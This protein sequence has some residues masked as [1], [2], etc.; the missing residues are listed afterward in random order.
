MKERL[1]V[2]LDPP[3]MRS[4][5]DYAD[6]RGKSKSLVAEAAIASFLSPD[7]AERLED[8]VEDPVRA[9]VHVQR[10]DDFIPGLQIR[11][12]HR[13]FG[14]EPGA[15]DGGVLH[16]FELRQSIKASWLWI[17]P[18][19]PT[20]ALGAAPEECYALIRANAARQPALVGR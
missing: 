13:I 16:A 6:R 11:L 4:L 17:R 19:S 8:L 5:I 10:D 1:S 7:A 15:E 2:Y 14:S 3:V 9:A 18:N 12:Q 20:G